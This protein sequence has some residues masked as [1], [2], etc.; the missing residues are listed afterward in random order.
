MLD[1]YTATKPC[2][3]TI[4]YIINDG[5]DKR[6]VAKEVSNW[7]R[8]GYVVDRVSLAEA[9]ENVKECKCEEV[10]AYDVPSL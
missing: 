2:G 7:I 6:S 4:A 10:A 9:E 5:N 1:V 8:C 3:C